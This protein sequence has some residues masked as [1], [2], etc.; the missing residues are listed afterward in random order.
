MIA[1]TLTW[2]ATALR[3]STA[4][5]IDGG[6]GRAGATEQDQYEPETAHSPLTFVRANEVPRLEFKAF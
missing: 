6:Q 2:L 5:L 4:K 3:R 1:L